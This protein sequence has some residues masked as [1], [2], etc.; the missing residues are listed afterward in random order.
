M[1]SYENHIK[2]YENHVYTYNPPPGLSAQWSAMILGGVL[3]SAELSVS[4]HF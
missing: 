4:K 2:S 1:K 3:H